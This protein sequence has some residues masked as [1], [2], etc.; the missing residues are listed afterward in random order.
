MSYSQWFRFFLVPVLGVVTLAVTGSVSAQSPNSFECT[1]SSRG[2]D[3]T[4]LVRDGRPDIS[5]IEWSNRLE[6]RGFPGR[7]RCNIVSQRFQ[8]AYDE[9]RSR[10]LKVGSVKQQSVVCAVASRNERCTSQNLL[11][12]VNPKRS[13]DPL[14]VLKEVLISQDGTTKPW[15]D[16][17]RCPSQENYVTSINGEK[18]IDFDY[19]ISFCARRN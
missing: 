17:A 13:E 16:S 10:F 18:V 19:L 9:G 11:F 7:A 12:T 3:S 4:T 1:P 5:L 6:K 15:F 2:Y 8:K 14:N